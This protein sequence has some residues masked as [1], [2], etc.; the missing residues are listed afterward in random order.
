MVLRT[1]AGCEVQVLKMPVSKIAEATVNQDYGV[2]LT[3]LNVFKMHSV[4]IDGRHNSSPC[5]DF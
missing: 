2:T 3:L 5:F 4:E 1:Y